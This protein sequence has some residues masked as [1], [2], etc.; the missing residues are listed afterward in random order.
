[1]A[2]TQH[3]PV[4]RPFDLSFICCLDESHNDHLM[5]VGNHSEGQYCAN[6]P[7]SHI[8]FQLSEKHLLWFDKVQKWIILKL[9]IVVYMHD[10]HA[11]DTLDISV[12]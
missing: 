5:I 6:C 11:M 8:E 12:K 2:K 3:F 10:N 4:K 1:M 9:I 7:K